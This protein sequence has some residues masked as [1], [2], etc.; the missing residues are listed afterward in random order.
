MT[1]HA[2]ATAARDE[3]RVLRPASD[4][5]PRARSERA[6][7]WWALG[8]CVLVALA[9]RAPYLSIPLGRDEELRTRRIGIGLF[10]ASP[11]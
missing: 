10:A 9:L 4:G 1:T 3:R 2:P 11:E 6:R 5:R 8:A 7:T